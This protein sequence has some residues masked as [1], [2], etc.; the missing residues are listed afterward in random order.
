M[1]LLFP[2]RKFSLSFLNCADI[3]TGLAASSSYVDTL[4]QGSGTYGLRARRGSFDNG[5]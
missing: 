5:I 2:K 1:K 3:L 4:Q